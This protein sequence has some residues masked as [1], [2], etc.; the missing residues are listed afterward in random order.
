LSGRIENLSRRFFAAALMMLAVATTGVA[1][2]A[3]PADEATGLTQHLTAAEHQDGPTSPALLPILAPLA[4]LRF[5]QGELA[6]A[7]AL[8]RRSLKIA[9]AAD[10]SVSI[11]AAEAMGALAHLYIERRRYLDAEPLA[12]AA[13]EVLT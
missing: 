1:A 2:A 3:R 5:E 4:Q 12:I 13:T 10:G 6:E 7:T 11:P 9:I 8:R